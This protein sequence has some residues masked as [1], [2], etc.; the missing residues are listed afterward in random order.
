MPHE[1]AIIV[2]AGPIGLACALSAK[3]RGIDPLVIDAGAVANSIVRYPIFWFAVAGAGAS[4]GSAMRRW[5]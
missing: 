1:S 3:R 2:G 4:R 5:S